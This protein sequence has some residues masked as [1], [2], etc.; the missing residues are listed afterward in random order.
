MIAA[1]PICFYATLRLLSW[2]NHM[3]Y[4]KHKLLCIYI[5][6]NIFCGVQ[7]TKNASLKSNVYVS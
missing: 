2:L 4:V 1:V 6:L 3:L 5:N 7:V